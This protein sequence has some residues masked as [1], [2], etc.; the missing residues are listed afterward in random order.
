AINL[1]VITASIVFLAP[2]ILQPILLLI[3]SRP[4]AIGLIEALSLL[5]V[6]G[7]FGFYHRAHDAVVLIFPILWSIESQMPNR[8]SIPIYIL[9]AVFYTGGT[10]THNF[11]AWRLISASANASDAWQLFI[12]PQQ[13]WAVLCLS[14]WV[15]YLIYRQF[16][17][18]PGLMS[19][20]GD[21][22]LA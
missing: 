6:V 14:V 9:A 16:L 5:Q 18:G 10:L 7:L 13:N 20:A 12:L 15:S 8:Q 1:I 3:S 4:P 22:Q 17:T 2:L 19:A 11:N 21:E